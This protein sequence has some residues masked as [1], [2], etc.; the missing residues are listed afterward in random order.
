MLL[1]AVLGVAGHGAGSGGRAQSGRLE[2]DPRHCGRGPRIDRSRVGKPAWSR[3]RL[4]PDWER[5]RRAPSAPGVLPGVLIGLLISLSV[6][7]E[8]ARQPFQS[9]SNAERCS[10]I[11]SGAIQRITCMLLGATT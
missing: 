10:A 4:A 6:S 9:P 3:R 7:H 5:W 8:T 1:S 11:S 2:Y